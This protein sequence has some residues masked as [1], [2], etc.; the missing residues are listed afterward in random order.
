MKTLILLAAL[1]CGTAQAATYSGNQLLTELNGDAST[2]LGAL[3]FVKGAWDG[4]ELAQTLAGQTA[5]CTPSDVVVGQVADIVR[6]DLTNRPAV[7]H[8]EAVMLVYVSLLKTWPC[9]VSPSKQKGQ[10]SL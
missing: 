1:L 8:E 7:R 9:K 4:I 10:Q 2:R 3:R 6:N 5:I